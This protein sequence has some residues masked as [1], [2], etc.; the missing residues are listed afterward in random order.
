MKTNDAPP[1]RGYERSDVN[2]KGAVVMTVGILVATLGA[3]LLMRPLFDHLVRR[4]ARN[5]PART[6][7]VATEPNPL[8]PE[9]RLQANPVEDLRE[10]RALERRALD[11]YAWVDRKAG[12]VRIPIERAIDLIALREA[13]E[14]SSR[15]P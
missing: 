5:Q 12:R 7:L 10:Y 1:G 3:M 13:N 15:T 14:R 8:P 11:G 6:T 9:P 2:A 4:E